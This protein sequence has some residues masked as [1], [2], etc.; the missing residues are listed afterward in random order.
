M[1]EI[2]QRA[3]GNEEAVR[4]LDRAW[5]RFRSDGCKDS[6]NLRG[7]KLLGDLTRRR[8]FRSAAAK[9]RFQEKE[10][11]IK[12]AVA[13]GVPD[14]VPVITNGLTLYPAFAGHSG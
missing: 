7:A 4:E 6:L 3:A 1:P 2:S 11:R 12:T 13:L 5:N 8:R 14:R 9:K 10:E